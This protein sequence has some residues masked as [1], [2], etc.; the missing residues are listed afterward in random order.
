MLRGQLV[1]DRNP[2]CVV[3]TV[4]LLTLLSRVK[5]WDKGTP[6]SPSCGAEGKWV[7]SKTH[8]LGSGLRRL[9]MG[10]KTDSPS[11]LTME[12]RSFR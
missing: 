10:A 6:K 12:S 2:P 8:Y 1:Q 3:Q 9:G 4:N 11:L 5:T 7:A